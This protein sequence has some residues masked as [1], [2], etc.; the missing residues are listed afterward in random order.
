MGCRFGCTAMGCGC[1]A[2]GRAC[3]SGSGGKGCGSFVV[4]SWTIVPTVPLVAGPVPVLGA[5]G[6]SGNGGNGS[7]VGSGGNAF[8]FAGDGSTA[9]PD[10]ISWLSTGGSLPNPD[11]AQAAQP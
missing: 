9:G 3:A 8:G 6:L 4:C 5:P 2:T 7:A 10:S 1:V 11:C